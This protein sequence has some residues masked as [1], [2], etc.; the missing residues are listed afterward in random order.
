MLSDKIYD[1]ILSYIPPILPFKVNAP[2]IVSKSKSLELENKVLELLA[3][4]TAAFIKTPEKDLKTATFSNVPVSKLFFVQDTILNAQRSLAKTQ[5]EKVTYEW[6]P[7]V[8]TSKGLI[9][10]PIDNVKLNVIKKEHYSALALFS[11]ITGIL[12]GETNV[13]TKNDV[14]KALHAL[15]KSDVKAFNLYMFF[16]KEIAV[17]KNKEALHDFK[18]SNYFEFISH[19]KISITKLLAYDKET[20]KSFENLPIDEKLELSYIISYGMKLN[21]FSSKVYWM[22]PNIFVSKMLNQTVTFE[23]TLNFFNRSVSVLD[24]VFNTYQDFNET[25]IEIKKLLAPDLEMFKESINDFNTFI[26]SLN[27]NIKVNVLNYHDSELISS[28][29]KEFVFET[30]VKESF[31]TGT[32]NEKVLWSLKSAYSENFDFEKMREV[33]ETLPTFEKALIFKAS[34][35]KATNIFSNF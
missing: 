4:E 8:L 7:W 19:Y 14:F 32:L 26:N 9:L 2:F 5:N 27:E 10:K 20:I 23:N 1:L 12:N 24:T 18:V 28:Y 25:F 31:K 35:K 22:L 16:K 13:E 11:L 34:N 6:M 33:F 15:V 17:L 30:E 21:I 3:S 29:Y